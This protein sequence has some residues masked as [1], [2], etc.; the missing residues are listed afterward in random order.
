VIKFTVNKRLV[1]ALVEFVSVYD[2]T[3]VS[4]IRQNCQHLTCGPWISTARNFNAKHIASLSWIVDLPS[5]RG[6]PAVLRLA[7][8]GWQWNGLLTVRTG[9]S[10]NP[11]LGS[12][13]VAL[14][15]T[16]NQR[17]NVLGD[18]RLADDRPLSAKLAQYFSPAAFAT[19]ATGTFGNA[20][21][22]VIVAPGSAAVNAGLFKNFPLPP[23]EGMK[24]QF[25]SEFFNVL[26]RVNLGSPNVTFG[27]S[28]GRITSAGSPRVLQFAMKLLF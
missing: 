28:M 5:L 1:T 7:A 2:Q 19:P 23:R 10:L 25:R 12:S 26:N 17:P 4:M 18:W 13:D 9:L 20:G 15:G 21:R 11:T 6:Q 16:A 14:S 22:N 24:L 8:G 3:R 27:S